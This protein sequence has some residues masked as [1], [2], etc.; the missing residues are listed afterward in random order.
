LEELSVDHAT[1]LDVA[2]DQKFLVDCKKLWACPHARV[3]IVQYELFCFT[4]TGKWSPRVETTVDFQLLATEL[5]HK[6]AEATEDSEVRQVAEWW[7]L[8]V[9]EKVRIRMQIKAFH[10]KLCM[11]GRRMRAIW[12]PDQALLRTQMTLLFACPSVPKVSLLRD[13]LTGAGIIFSIR[14]QGWSCAF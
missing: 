13:N 4:V 9:R 8:Y 11:L 5:Q 6:C 7:W 10:A 3:M 1:R 12:D 14:S 2:R